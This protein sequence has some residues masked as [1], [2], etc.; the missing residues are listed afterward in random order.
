MTAAAVV[1]KLAL[2]SSWAKASHGFPLGVWNFARPLLFL[3]SRI[4]GGACEL[5]LFL[6]SLKAVTVATT[7]LLSSGWPHALLSV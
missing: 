7:V 5:V 1:P 4:A 3:L 6:L 2:P